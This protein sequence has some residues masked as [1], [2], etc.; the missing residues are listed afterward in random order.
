[1]SVLERILT[2]WRTQ[3]LGLNCGKDSCGK[4]VITQVFDMLA[5]TDL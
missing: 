1:M 4:E 3:A 2:M 5:Y